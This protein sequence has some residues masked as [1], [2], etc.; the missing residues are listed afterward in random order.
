MP[1]ILKNCRYD[2]V[3]TNFGY[4]TKLNWIQNFVRGKFQTD[5][6]SK[7]VIFSQFATM[8]DLI[9]SVLIVEGYPCLRFD[10]KVAKPESRE[11]IKTLFSEDDRFRI[12]LVALK[13]GGV[14]LN[15]VAAKYLIIVDPWYERNT[16]FLIV[17]TGGT[18]PQKPKQK[19]EY[20]G[21]DRITKLRYFGC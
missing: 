19:T 2:D 12:I 7:L 18:S 17:K 5:S 8:L 3:D 9:E 6:N 11:K 1:A 21:S 16:P 20:T 14:G 4:S 10:G 13:A 15:L